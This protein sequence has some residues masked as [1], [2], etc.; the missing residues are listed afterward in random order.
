[1]VLGR[2]ARFEKLEEIDGKGMSPE[3]EFSVIIPICHGGP[4][5]KA[6]L[7]SIALLNYPREQFEILFTGLQSDKELRQFVE[8]DLVN[9]AIDISYIGVASSN[10]SVQLNAAISRARGRTLVFA[11]DDCVFFPDWLQKIR[12]V[13]D[14]ESDTGAIGGRDR[15]GEDGSSFSIALGCVLNSFMGTGGI[16]GRSGLSLG[17]YY[18]RLWNMAVPREVAL[19]V[20]IRDPEGRIQVFDERLDVHEDVELMH[21]IEKAGKRIIHAPDVIVMHSRDTTLRSFAR[22]SFNMAR[23]CRSIGVHRFPH[24][25]MAAFAVCFILLLAGS[26]LTD[27]PRMP[28]ALISLVY[29]AILIVSA[30]AC[31]MRSKLPCVFVFLPLLL[32]VLYFSRG[33]GYLFPWPGRSSGRER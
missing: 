8:S 30:V 29:G 3:I 22:R 32:T 13:L 24:L 28:L 11:D 17:K 19:S 15:T 7:E 25:C 6:A 10:K 5:L 21:R 2:R 23:T 9:R 12:S 16:R 26:M 14:K 31:F 1:M 18:P 20:L 4:F 33:L 27:W